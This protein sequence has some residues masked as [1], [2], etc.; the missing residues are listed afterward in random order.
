M[1]P[2]GPQWDWWKFLIYAAFA[3]FG[4]V[5][6]HLMRAIDKNERIHWG[7]TILQGLAAGFV[8]VIVYMTCLA[9]GLSDLWTGV[10]VGVFGWVGADSTIRILK[11]LV[12][13]K[14][15]IPD[16]GSDSSQEDSDGASR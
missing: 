7:V 12:L 16:I 4:G 1:E 14:L 15:N 8:G 9:M 2:T 5:M 10:V 11:T 6:G 13:K 3:S